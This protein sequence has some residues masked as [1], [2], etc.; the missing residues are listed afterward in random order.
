MPNLLYSLTGESISDPAGAVVHDPT[1]ADRSL[2]RRRRPADSSISTA[3]VDEQLPDRAHDALM[4]VVHSGQSA[5]LGRQGRDTRSCE[6]D[7][8]HQRFT[9]CPK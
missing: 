1:A 9:K 7:P 2:P 6:I 4:T 3:H 8:M 5:A